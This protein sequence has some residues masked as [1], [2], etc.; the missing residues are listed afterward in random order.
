MVKHQ[1]YHK[2]NVLD[3]LDFSELVRHKDNII[4]KGQGA[5][6]FKEDGSVSIDTELKDGAL[7]DK[8][9]NYAVSKEAIF[10]FQFNIENFIKVYGQ[11]FYPAFK[12][13]E[14]LLSEVGVVNPRPYSARAYRH[15]NPHIPWHKH[16]LSLSVKP[17][18]FWITIFY[19]H[20]NWDMKY[21]GGLRVGLSDTENLFV[22]DCL[23]NSVV[24]HNGYYGHG[25]LKVHPGFE[26]N[27]DI[28][29]IH[30]ISD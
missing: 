14:N 20:P 7:D 19:L 9:Y 25:V 17:S 1:I 8:P 10:N 16:T 29:L 27:R 11:E 26:G 13:I 21:G 24:M 30:W 4:N 22:F 28:L 3:E 18:K 5:T 2:L 23:S 15:N 12:N 6:T